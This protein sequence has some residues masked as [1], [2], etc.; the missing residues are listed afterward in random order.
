MH[1]VQINISNEKLLLLSVY[2]CKEFNFYK[3]KKYIHLKRFQAQMF[4]PNIFVY[5]K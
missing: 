5:S 4:L 2:P 1:Y 3:G